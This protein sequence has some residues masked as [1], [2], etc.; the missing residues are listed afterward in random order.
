M[1]CFSAA[2]APAI[3]PPV[4]AP[5]WSPPATDPDSI[6]A[7]YDPCANGRCKDIKKRPNMETGAVIYVV[8]GIIDIDRS[9]VSYKH[10]LTDKVSIQLNLKGQSRKNQCGF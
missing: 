7:N 5:S 1:C 2:Q 4:S 6:G 3:T 9:N 8:L 10:V